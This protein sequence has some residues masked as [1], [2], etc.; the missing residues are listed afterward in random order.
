MKTH[1]LSLRPIYADLDAM[2]VVY[3][4]NYF[5]FFEQG[6][7]ELMRGTGFPYALAEKQG[8]HFPVSEAGARYRD[9]ARY[10]ELLYLDTWVGWLR[11][12][13]LRFEYR[14]VRPQEDKEVELVS[15]FTVHGCISHSGKIVPLPEWA[16]QALTP[17]VAA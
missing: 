14:L 3:Y 1:R 15:G 12:V 13:S 4:A 7:T 9:S 16:R 10:D 2:D 6:R 11:K 8:L 5:R 17:F